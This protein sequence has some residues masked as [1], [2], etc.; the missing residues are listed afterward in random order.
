MHLTI[1]QSVGEGGSNKPIDVMNVDAVLRTIGLLE[2][3]TPTE[4]ARNDAIKRF[5]DIWGLRNQGRVDGR[6]D[7]NGITLRKLNETAAAP[8]LNA[9]ELKRI[10]KGG[11]KVSFTAAPLAP[12]PYALWL[13]VSEAPGD[14]FDVTGCNPH[15]VMTSTNLPSLLRLIQKHHRWGQTLH[16]KLFVTLN[17][18]VIA[19]SHS[20]PLACPVFPH[21][22]K[23]LPLQTG[24]NGPDLTYQGD[25]LADHFWGRWLQKAEG[26]D[27]YLFA[28]FFDPTG[29]SKFETD[30]AHRGFD[31]ITYAGTV[32]GA[33]PTKLGATSNLV[34]FLNPAKCSYEKQ[35]PST[36]PGSPP[37]AVAIELENAHPRDIAEYFKKNSAGYYIM[38]SGG[39]VVLVVNGAVHEFRASGSAGYRALDVQEWLKVHGKQSVRKLMGKPARAE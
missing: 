6:I 8:K 38:W 12:P 32:C 16:V 4:Q 35:V 15:D 28:Y 17:S 9:I 18:K 36:K 2:N 39:H 14:Y 24:G 5:Q 27:S 33:P 10:G 34:A 25:A 22:G 3:I 20:R 31:C 23:L 29:D 21:N 1:S 26:F 7:P 11:Y 30:P 13:G 37:T 19:T